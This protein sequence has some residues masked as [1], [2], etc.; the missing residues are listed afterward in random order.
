VNK[1]PF[2]DSEFVILHEN[3]KLVSPI[4]VVYFERYKDD[5]D[6]AQKL[7]SVADKIQVVVAK[8]GSGHIPF[9]SAQSPELLDYADRVDTLKFL[10]ELA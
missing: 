6:L 8:A 4:S 3:E 7:A 2:Y 1:I 10:E 9:G 5:V